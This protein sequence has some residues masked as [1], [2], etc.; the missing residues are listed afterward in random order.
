VKQFIPLRVRIEKDTVVRINRILA[1]KGK[2]A[3]S[4][5]QEVKPSDILATSDISSGFRTLDLASLLSVEGREVE[6]Y[7]KRGVGQI[8]YKGE[9][10][11]YKDGG[12]FGSKKTVI[13]PTDG[14]LDYLNPEDGE[15]RMTLLPKK[16]ELPSGVYGIVESVDQEKGKVVIRTQVSRIHGV[17]G[18]GRL[19]DGILE[20][21]GK[22]EDL[23]TSAMIS[24]KDEG[25]ILVAGSLIYKDALSNAISCG[26]NGLI[27]GGMNAKDYRS[28]AGGKI[29]FPKKLE[30]DIGISILVTEGFGS[31]PIA[32][33]IYELLQKYDGKFVSIDGNKAILDLPSFESSSLAKVKSTVLPPDEVSDEHIT[34]AEELKVGMGV[35]VI[36]TSFL[37]EQG[38]I[39]S[40][41][42]SVTLIPSG[43][44]VFMAV[45]ETKR[46]K[47]KVPVVNLEAI[48]YI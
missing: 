4:L 9:L 14:I 11:A 38:K 40:I 42:E 27:V 20:F 25:H 28:M 22:R 33:D 2:I 24:P 36:G 23:L 47:I 10:L 39:I 29:A 30:N 6:K 32:L 3:V 43:L 46:R 16:V 15:L 48:D 35:R 34:K 1:G 31:V 19:R 13:A 7:L 41:D 44:S 37:G 26:V 8:I 18:C 45:I 12:L 17:F 21:I 5:N